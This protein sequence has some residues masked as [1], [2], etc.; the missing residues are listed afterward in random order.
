MAKPEVIAY[1]QTYLNKFPVDELRQQ[2]AQEGVTASEFDEAM[3]VAL[4]TPLSKKKAPG[5]G[6][7]LLLGA[8]GLLIGVGAIWILIQRGGGRPQPGAPAKP[9]ANA[10]SAFVGYFGY[11]V[12]L[13]QEYEAMAKPPDSPKGRETVHFCRRGTDPTSFLHEGL[14]GQLGIVRLVVEPNRFAEAPNPIAALTYVLESR[15]QQRGEKFVR[16]PLN[17]GSLRGVQLAV[18]TP[19]PRTEAY[20]LGDKVLY[21][22]TAGQDDEV[23][24]ELLTSL[25]EAGG[26]M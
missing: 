7:K 10:E 4:R 26:E 14:F 12:R 19:F 16:K 6:G 23:F 8:G 15:L 21:I 22:F 25:R 24:R 9:S 17:V 20:V 18:E 5:S 2:L 3:K 1:L 13:P 11:V